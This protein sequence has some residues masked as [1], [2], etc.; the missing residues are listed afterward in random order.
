[1]GF[2]FDARALESGASLFED[3]AHRLVIVVTFCL[4]VYNFL[5]VPVDDGAVSKTEHE[6]VVLATNGLILRNLGVVLVVRLFPPLEGFRQLI[7]MLGISQ[8]EATP[9]AQR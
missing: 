8:I 3:S 7:G 1:M 5:E 2:L 4:R 6:I 9:L